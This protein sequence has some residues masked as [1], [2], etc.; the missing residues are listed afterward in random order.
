MEKIEQINQ[1]KRDM[2]SKVMAL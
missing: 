1:L 2:A